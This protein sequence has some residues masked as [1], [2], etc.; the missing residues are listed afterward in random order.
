MIRL[1]PLP[2]VLL[3]VLLPGFAWTL[4]STEALVEGY[5]P[6]G[7]SGEHCPLPEDGEGSPDP[8]A[9]RDTG[10]ASTGTPSPDLYCQDLLATGRA[11]EATGVVELAPA[12]SPF[13]VSVTRDGVHRYQFRARVQGLPDPAE[14]GD[15]G[16]FMAWLVTPDLMT[17]I[18]LG[19]V[20][21]GEAE[22][23]TAALH[24][25]LF[26]ITAEEDGDV[27]ERSGPT[28][29][30]GTSPS[31]VM[32]PHDE[33]PILAQM[34]AGDPD[35]EDV[36]HA[37]H[38]DPD[39]A[40]PPPEEHPHA[41]E[42]PEPDGSVAW[43]PPPMHPRVEMPHEMMELRPRADPYLPSVEDEERVPRVRPTEAVHVAD[44]DSIHLT[45]G[46]VRREIGDRSF[47][48]YGFNEQVPGPLLMAE[49][50]ATV[51]IIVE[52]RTAF[53]S[54]VHWHG[55]RLENRFD[56]VPGVTQEPIPPGETFR[57]E[58]DLPDAGTFW[59]HPHLR[60]DVKQDLGLYGNLHVEARDP[61][62][63]PEVDREEFVVL[64]DLLVADQG[65]VPYGRETPI[66][67]L[68]G[69]FGNTL[70]V[71]GTP[72]YDLGVRPGEVVRFHL[73]NVAAT[74]TFNV[75]LAGPSEAPAKVV[76]SDVGRFER[77][78]SVENVVIA[79]AERYVV[80]VHFPEEGSWE[81]ENR[82]QAMDH[83]AAEFFPE[84]DTL[85]TVRAEGD[86][87]DGGPGEGFHEVREFSEVT[88]EM[89]AYREAMEGPVDYELVLTLELGDLPFPLGPMINFESVYNHPVEW[90][91][92]MPDMD[93][94]VT[95]DQ[96]RWILRDP[97]SGAENMDIDWRFQEG[98][99]VKL[100][101]TND[102]DSYHPMQHPIH[103]HGQRFLVLSRNGVPQENRAW[104]DTVLVPVGETVELL[105]ELSNPGEWMVHCHISEHLENGMM[106]VF[107]VEEE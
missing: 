58:V 97:E 44:G 48:M 101:L 38:H 74:R 10:H 50:D 15:Y 47:V 3:A 1:R 92:T 24:S 13:G 18:P 14:L 60:E 103:I 51:T 27:E 91:G 57:Y 61:D 94:L 99:V 104:K 30:R 21:E 4:G 100:R 85:G 73:T 69:R 87:V 64:D 59:Y 55:I 34:A 33:L 42:G 106:F 77:E 22:L 75:S 43:F 41:H 68:M 29:L 28:V 46:P 39:A 84:V 83:I 12:P 2:S 88:R 6:P 17:S 53:P 98:D 49:E 78:E 72:G 8:R 52:N 80:D 89:E 67:A 66:H 7:A 25:F 105:L 102:A 54:A 65:L 31:M 90:A 62:H 96:V 9:G 56:G 76:A 19:E 26:L 81:L 93:W 37:H 35:T 45:A 79:P 11:P 36:P 107:D 16:A 23:E 82:V 70:L 95:G 40:E 32:R 71:N 5:A 63:L 20:E 86:P